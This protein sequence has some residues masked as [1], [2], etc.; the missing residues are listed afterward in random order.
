[1]PIGLSKARSFSPRYRGVSAGAASACRHDGR[2]LHLLRLLRRGRR[3]LFR[4]RRRLGDVEGLQ[5]LHRLL[6]NAVGKAG[7]QRVA[8]QCMQDRNAH[9]RGQ[10]AAGHALIVNVRH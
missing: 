9:D 4:R 8:E 1:L 7:D 5:V 10:T 6:S 2:R 3:L